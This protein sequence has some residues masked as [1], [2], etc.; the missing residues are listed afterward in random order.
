MIK[1]LLTCLMVLSLLTFSVAVAD[2]AEHL[3]VA[4]LY[5]NDVHC[6]I[7][8]FIGYAGLK[9]YESAYEDS[10]YQVA[11]VDSGDAIQG[12]SVG[13][14]SKGSYIIDIMNYVGYDV[15]AIGNHE[16]DYG[17]DQF[18]SLREKAEFPY[19]SANFCD[20]EGDPVLE[21]YAMLELGGWKVAFVG[22]ST[23]ETLLNPRRHTSRMTMEIIYIVSV[24]ATTARIFTILCNARLIQPRRRSRL[25]ICAKP[26]GNIGLEQAIYIQRF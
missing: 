25:C 12:G 6:G 4:V 11:I 20:I 7:D 24:K 17:M 22:A 21:P 23:P 13:T 19:V 8:E 9:A 16:F 18:T 14:L 26:F 5:T 3:P 10:G 1:R 2:E 15:A